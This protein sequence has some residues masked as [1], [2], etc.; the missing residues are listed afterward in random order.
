MKIRL[1]Q[2]SILGPTV[3]RF[4]IV[5]ISLLLLA[6]SLLHIASRPIQYDVLFFLDLAILLGGIWFLLMGLFILSSRSK[7][8]PHVE[9]EDTTV[10]IHNHIFGKTHNIDLN[11]ISKIMFGSFELTFVRYDGNYLTYRINTRKSS[12]SQKIKEELR[13][14][15]AP[16]SIIIEDEIA[17]MIRKNINTQK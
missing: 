11:N 16:Q 13:R 14:I 10:L 9:I 7:Y 3:H 12:E 5:L 2:N 17:A 8:V 15:A 6:Q 1:S 4:V